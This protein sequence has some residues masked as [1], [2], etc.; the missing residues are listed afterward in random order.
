MN[1]HQLEENREV[2]LWVTGI[3]GPVIIG[4]SNIIANSPEVRTALW[5]KAKEA[6]EAVKTK[7]ISK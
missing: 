4:V 7:L 6:Y 3:L 2:R 5:L 1:S